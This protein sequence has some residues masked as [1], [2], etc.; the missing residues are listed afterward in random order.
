[1]AVK[2]AKIK[3]NAKVVQGPGKREEARL[4][5]A[6]R[7]TGPL[8][9][10][11][12]LHLQRRIK[13]KLVRYLFIYFILFFIAQKCFKYEVVLTELSKKGLKCP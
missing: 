13:G 12:A 9:L 2:V 11:P 10:P 7:H 1:M 4:G 6:R 5:R 3:M 8:P